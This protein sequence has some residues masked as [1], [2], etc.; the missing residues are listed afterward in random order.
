MEFLCLGLSPA[1][2]S[3]R[4]FTKPPD[5]SQAYR[6]DT[7][8]PGASNRHVLSVALLNRSEGKPEASGSGDEVFPGESK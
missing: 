7:R 5:C 6:E 2:I 4:F 1:A 8:E 3:G